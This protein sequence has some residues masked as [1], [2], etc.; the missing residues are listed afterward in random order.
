MKTEDG[1]A[2][3]EVQFESDAVWLNQKQF[4]SIF[5]TKVPAINK[6]IRNIEV[7]NLEIVISMDTG[8]I[9]KLLK[10]LHHNGQKEESTESLGVLLTSYSFSII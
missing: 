6:Y 3:I 7:Y 4:A 10:H 2:Q 5:G 8:L 9:L 1:K